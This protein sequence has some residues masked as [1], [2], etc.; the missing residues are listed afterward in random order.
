[1]RF[2]LPVLALLALSPLPA[3]ADDNAAQELAGT[4]ATPLVGPM[5]EVPPAQ[6]S[7]PPPEDQQVQLTPEQQNTAALEALKLAEEM[8]RARRAEEK[9][10]RAEALRQEQEL[11]DRA[12]NLSAAA[13]KAQAEIKSKAAKGDAAAQYALA[14]QYEFGSDG[15]KQNYKEAAKW[16]EKA[17]AKKYGDAAYRLGHLYEGGGALPENMKQAAEWFRTGAYAGDTSAQ[18]AL[19]ELYR[20]GRSV[21]QDDVTAYFWI[22][23]SAYNGNRAAMTDWQQ[24]PPLTV[25]QIGDVKKRVMEWVPER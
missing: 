10:A 19:G 8:A 18:A 9:R 21:P 5:T 3:L 1:M 17:A 2:L 20:T 23:L 11:R 4:E 15:M 25:D 22:S 16:Y 13:K 14:S 6:T 24:N 12:K 7:E